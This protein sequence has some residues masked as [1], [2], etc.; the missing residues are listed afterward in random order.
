MTSFIET[1]GL[2]EMAESAE[3]VQSRINS[4]PRY[5]RLKM[6]DHERLLAKTLHRAN[7]ETQC[8]VCGSV[9]DTAINHVDCIVCG[10]PH[11]CS[12]YYL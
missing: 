7:L 4:W 9:M 5:W 2:K 12:L 1:T 3:A 8:T 6:G 10:S 11:T